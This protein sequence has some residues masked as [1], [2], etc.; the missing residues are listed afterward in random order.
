MPVGQKKYISLDFTDVSGGVNSVEHPIR[1]GPTQVQPESKGFILKRSGLEKYPG[2]TGLIATTTFTTYLKMLSMYRN[3]SGSESLL[4]LSGGKLYDVDIEGAGIGSISE[5]YDLTGTGEGWA[6]D[7]YGKHWILNGSAVVKNESGTVYRV[8]IA[9]PSGVTAA[10]AAGG[11]MPD[12]VYSL[13]ASYGR[14]VS[15]VDKLY[16]QG[17]YVGN[18][19]LGS[20]NNTINVTAFPNSSDGQVGQKVIW[21]K[22]T[23]T[24]EV[25]HYFLYGT[26]NNT[27][28]TF[29]ITSEAAKSTSL[30]YEYD[31]LDNGLPPNGDFIYAFANRIWIIDDNIIYYSD[32]AFSEYDLE[33][34]RAANYLVTPYKCTGMFSVGTN[35]YVNTDQGIM[36]I[37]SADPTAIS[38]IIEPRWHFEYMRTVARW[39]NGVIGVTNDGV[40]YFDGERFT[41]YD[42]SYYI[43]NKVAK[44]YESET[45]F[46]P[47]GYVFRR[48]MRNEYHLLWQDQTVS[49]NVNNTHAILNLDV[50]YFNS[51]IDNNMAWEFQHFSGNYAAVSAN[52][53]TV[54]IG[55]SHVAASKIYTESTS[56]D[57]AKDVYDCEGTLYTELTSPYSVCRTRIEMPNI[58]AIIWPKKFYVLSQNV[59]TFSIRLVIPDK[60]QTESGRIPVDT[61]IE[62]GGEVAVWDESVFDSSYYPAE[63]AAVTRKK[64]KDALYGRSCYIEIV[65]QAN[66]TGFRLMQVAVI[67]EMETGNFL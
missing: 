34:F 17:Q 53:N 30:V 2:A 46:Q 54:Y 23:T 31:A 21:A 29:T 44:I 61:S 62:S 41:N 6:C 4:A 42:I 13:Y 18:V 58:T 59:A 12:G 57:Q 33:I 64:F 50:L 5:L 26:N 45:N 39:N 22:N 1:I 19:T 25:I 20:G 37:P 10:A 8:G 56:T 16:S 60:F 32:K 47:V 28:T 66:D 15:G 9:A 14:R 52:D 65:Q 43:K 49:T 36:I 7:S 48:G 35:L 55:Q 38:Y 11:T 67:A 24:G 51:P 3:F 63:N 27:T 40:R